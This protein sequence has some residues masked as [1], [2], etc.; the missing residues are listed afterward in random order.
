[1]K[2]N[3]GKDGYYLAKKTETDLELNYLKKEGNVNKLIDYLIQKIR[4]T[5]HAVDVLTIRS[6][7]FEETGDELLRFRE[8]LTNL[9]QEFKDEIRQ[10][11]NQFKTLADKDQDTYEALRALRQEAANTIFNQ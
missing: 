5:D 1:M 11:H 2:R 10:I 6:G 7:N 9:N 3:T 8:E 4:N